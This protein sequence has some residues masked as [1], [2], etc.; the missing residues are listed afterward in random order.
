M[1]R[2]LL[3]IRAIAVEFAKRIYS[4]I[5]IIFSVAVVV[6][7]GLLAW[8]TTISA[9]WWIFLILV[10]IGTV[11]G[12]VV[13]VVVG[14]ILRFVKP[15]MT[16]AQNKMVGTFVDKLQRLS[17]ITQTPKILLLFR[18]VK[19]IASPSKNGFI[20]SV[21]TDTTSLKKDF[22]DLLNSF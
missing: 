13:L 12:I 3:V 15:D 5:A 10:I 9:W 14:L 7:I 1:N 16:K 21:A 2:S 20:Q 4:P 6:L 19:D 17:E 8:L 18:A 11:I 22:Q